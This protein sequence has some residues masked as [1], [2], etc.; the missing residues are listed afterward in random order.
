MGIGVLPCDTLALESGIDVKNGVIVDEFCRT[1]NGSVFSAGD[2]TIH[3]NIFYNKNIRLESVH[4]AI[5]QGKTVAA[6]IMGENISYNQVPWFWSDQY[7]TKLQIVG[8]LDNYDD[9]VV[10][11]DTKKQ[12]FAVFY[13]K[14]N[15]ITASDCVNRPA[16]H[17]MSRKLISEKIL[18]DKNRLSDET[19]PIKEVAN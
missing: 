6:S 10:R 12:S 13:T 2:C 1:S 14:D 9:I 5:E 17:M 11:G 7:E 15:R 18:I 19:I 8:L 3:P 4:N 16:E